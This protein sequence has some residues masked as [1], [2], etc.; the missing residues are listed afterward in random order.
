M[1]KKLLICIIAIVIIAVGA[2]MANAVG[3]NKGLEYGDYTRI[4]VYM[5][6]ESNLEDVNGLVKEAFD[7]KYEIAYTDEFKDTVSIK[8]QG[9][10]DEQIESLKNK[11]KEKYEFEDDAEFLVTLNT[12]GVGTYDLIKDYIKP[13][14]IS[15]IIILAYFGITYRKLGIVEGLAE[16]AL[17]LIILNC[18]YVSAIA[19]FR[20]L[21]NAYII[22]LGVFIY[23]M[24]ILG[25]TIYLNSK[26]RSLASEEK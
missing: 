7:G 1:N 25:V 5:N 14:T 11:L 9:I 8:A 10:S 22:P 17:A 3:F 18:L 13:V 12:A 6:K 24:S 16:P 19:I 21:L 23:I 20:I 4:L 26:N 15:F 2:V